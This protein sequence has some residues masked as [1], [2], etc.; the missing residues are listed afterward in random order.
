MTLGGMPYGTTIYVAGQP[1]LT[2]MGIIHMSLDFGKKLN[3]TYINPLGSEGPKKAYEEYI[4]STESITARRLAAVRGI[5]PVTMNC[6]ED[7]DMPDGLLDQIMDNFT[8]DV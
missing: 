7:G 3:C 5:G 8:A 4:T 1:K 6:H 2:S